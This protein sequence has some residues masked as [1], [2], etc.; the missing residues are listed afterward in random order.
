[1]T[2]DS[3]SCWR[4]ANHEDRIHCGTL[5][6]RGVLAVGCGGPGTVEKADTAPFNTLLVFNWE[7][8]QPA[9]APPSP[10]GPE[11]PQGGQPPAESETAP[12]L[13]S[14]DKPDKASPAP[15]P[16]AAAAPAPA[17]E[18]SGEPADL[19]ASAPAAFTRQQVEDALLD[20]L[21]ENRVFSNF[22]T[23]TL[24]TMGKRARVEKSDLIVLVNFKTFCD[25]KKKPPSTQTGLAS[26]NGVLWITTG[27]GAWW[28]GDREYPTS[29]EIEMLWGRPDQPQ[30]A[31]PPDPVDPKVALET[32]RGRASREPLS[33]GEYKLSLWERARPWRYPLPYLV[34]ILV[35]PAF[36]PMQ[37]QDE[38]DRSVQGAALQD[39]S[40]EMARKLKTE[41]LRAAGA[42]FLFRLLDPA[43]GIESTD[44][45]EAHLPVRGGAEGAEAA[46]RTASENA[47]DRGEA[48]RGQAVPKVQEYRTKMR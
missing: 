34:G 24:S 43:N 3:A 20:G 44:P 22:E 17:I 39:L 41:T 15:A 30:A 23:A 13:E 5:S 8:P 25:W 28:L 35:P 21:D 1:M 18:P 38:V 2:L 47:V 31:Q 12:E 16:T 42:P 4:L 7:E 45:C 40:R 26:V 19:P 27:V 6:R 33:T 32:F 37:D 9:I 48:G 46:C 11:G 36:L 29:S 14:V 10:E